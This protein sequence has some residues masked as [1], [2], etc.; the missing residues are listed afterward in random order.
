MQFDRAEPYFV[1]I[2]EGGWRH[3][4]TFGLLANQQKIGS[5]QDLLRS[6]SMVMQSN[7]PLLIS[8]GTWEGEYRLND[9]G[10]ILMHRR[11]SPDAGCWRQSKRMLEGH[12]TGGRVITEE[13]DAQAGEHQLGRARKVVITKVNTLVDTNG[14]LPRRSGSDPARSAPSSNTDQDFD[15]AKLR[16]AGKTRRRRCGHQVGA[17]TETE[18]R[19]R[20][21][22]RDALSATRAA[23]EGIVPGAWQH[24]PGRL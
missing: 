22:R 14:H 3:S 15:R 23:R 2:P 16:A 17:A 19:R 9:R 24:A 4:S 10:C 13:L 20:S 21:V 18:L 8:P 5:S 7:K 11:R 12:A 1:T 6:S